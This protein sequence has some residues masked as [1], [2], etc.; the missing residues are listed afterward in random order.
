MRYTTFVSTIIAAL[1]RGA[2]AAAVKGSAEGFAKGVTGGGSASAVYPTTTA[3]LVSYLGDSSARNIY[4]DRTFDFTGSEG[5]ASETGCAPYGTA[6]GCQT[7]INKNDWCTNYQPNSPKVNVKYDKAAILGITVKSNKSIIGVGSAGVIKGK[8]LRIVSGAK[9]VIIQNI[10]ITN[11]NPQYVWGGDAITID[12]SDMVWIDHVT[13]SLIGRQHIVLGN[14]PSGRVTISNNFIDGRTSWSATCNG[15]HYWGLYFTGSNDMVTFK[16]NYIYHTSGRSPKV[17]GNTLLHAVN[18]YWHDNAGHAFE[19]DAGGQVL[20]EGNVFQNVNA[21]LDTSVA[22]KLF[23]SPN[24]SANAA[25]SASLGRACQV[26]GFGSSGSFSGTDTS[27]LVNF[28]GK[29]IA[30]ASSYETAKNVP[31][32]AGFGK[33]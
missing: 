10:H 33:I 17:A 30:S 21:P 26:N 9:N 31:N 12:N 19:I 29:N 6:S 1:L 28:Q 16:G 8:G 18:N 2:D 13:T 25:C 15:Y 4:L 24:T 22:G 3:Q 7:A 32:T 20:A 11:L 23:S 5:T 14:N 27:F